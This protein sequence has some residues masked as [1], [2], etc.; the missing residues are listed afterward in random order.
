MHKLSLIA[1][2][3]IAV[4]PLLADAA[5][6]AT[7]RGGEEQI[8]VRGQT[9]DGCPSTSSPKKES[10]EG[11]WLALTGTAVVV[12]ELFVLEGKVV[13]DNLAERNFFKGIPLRVGPVANARIDER[14]VNT[15]ARTEHD[16]KLGSSLY[17]FIAWS[18]WGFAIKT[19]SLDGKELITEVFG[20][21]GNDIPTIAYAQE[22]D[23]P[24]NE[25]GSLAL[26]RAG[27]FNGDGVVDLLLQ[28]SAKEATGLMLWLSDPKTGKHFE[29]FVS[30]TEY[31]DCG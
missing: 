12:T 6:V 2:L 17:R 16:I 9:P 26:I 14:H 4:I 23:D 29:P 25:L 31:Y 28:Y 13:S 24:D 7:G 1:A 10:V 18:S 19:I 11:S 8:A 21:N 27:D 5:Q 15:P 20:G 3:V 30:A 22:R